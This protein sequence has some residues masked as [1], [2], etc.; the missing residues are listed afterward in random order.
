MGRTFPTWNSL[1]SPPLLCIPTWRHC[2]ARFPYSIFH[3]TI[4][5]T[6][7]VLT[8]EIVVGSAGVGQLVR[9]GSVAIRYDELRSPRETLALMMSGVVDPGEPSP[10][11]TPSTRRRASAVNIVG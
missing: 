8:N 9:K 3:A 7:R 11:A 4:G 6:P 2:S 5:F 1:A 10:K